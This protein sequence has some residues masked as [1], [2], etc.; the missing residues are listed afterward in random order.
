MPARERKRQFQRLAF[1]LR[2]DEFAPATITSSEHRPPLA[3][4]EQRGA[5]TGSTTIARRHSDIE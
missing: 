1:A 3:T 5:W 2:A 4:T